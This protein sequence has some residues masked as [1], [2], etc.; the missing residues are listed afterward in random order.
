MGVE[1][2]RVRVDDEWVDLTIERKDDGITVTSPNHT[3]NADLRQFSG[4]NLV[5][6]I[7]DGLSLEFLVDQDGE[8]FTVL[9]D[10]E[11]YEVRVRPAWAAAAAGGDD[12]ASGE[13]IVEC[14]LVGVVAQVFVTQ[15]QEVQ[16]GDVLL[17]IEAMKMQ[18]EIRAPR[19]ATVR[20]V[21]VANGDKVA[22]RQPLIALS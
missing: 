16:R 17:T 6:L 14:P 2:F 21:H 22:Q 20:T 13:V 7:L 3:W 1:R 12:E 15:G 8:R 11:H 18:N 5:S 19:A 4:T 9:R 10:S